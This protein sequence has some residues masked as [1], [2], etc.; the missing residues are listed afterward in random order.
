MAADTQQ[1]SQRAARTGKR[2]GQGPKRARRMQPPLTSMIDVTFLLLLFFLLTFTFRE[3]EGQI[4]GALPR[5]G[6]EGAPYAIHVSVQSEGATSACYEIAGLNERIRDPLRLYEALQDIQELTHSRQ[7]PVVI[8]PD[9]FVPWS[10][11][12]EVF[13]Q[14][15]RLKFESV[16]FAPAT[17]RTRQ[18]S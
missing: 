15:L 17:G 9:A 11:V 2:L 12:V 6:G 3:Y 13:N 18:R 4:P 16:G 1:S 8:A 14:A 7:G 5:G 10:H